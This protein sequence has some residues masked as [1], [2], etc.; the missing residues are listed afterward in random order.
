M[1]IPDAVLVCLF[2]ALTAGAEEMRY[3]WHAPDRAAK[4]AALIPGR[5]IAMPPPEEFLADWTRRQRDKWA[6]EHEELPLEEAYQTY[7]RAEP[8][9]EYLTTL[10]PDHISP[11]G[12]VVAG[13]PDPI[14]A[15]GVMI[16]Y[17]PFCGMQTAY[18]SLIRA[19]HTNPFHATTACCNQDLYEREQDFPP[20]YKL[21]P[22]SSAKFVHLDGTVH[23]PSAYTFTDKHGV[24]WRLFIG[25]VVTHTRWER[26]ASIAVGF[27]NQYRGTAN[28]LYAHKLAVLL[29]R[30][31]DVYY[32]LPLSYRNEL[33]KGRDGKPMTRAEW[34]ALPRPVRFGR[35]Y[36][37]LWNRRRPLMSRCWLFQ[38]KECIWVEPFARVRHHPTFKH[39]SKTKYGDP[40]A[41]DRKI[42]TKL[43][44][45]IALMFES[46]SLQSDY[47]DGAYTELMMLGI[48]LGNRYLFNFAAAHQE[49]VLYNHHYHDGMNGE[50]APNYMA[51]LTE[52]YRYLRDPKGWLELA[53]DFLEEHPF[54]GPAS[55]ELRKLYTVRGLPLEF[56][57][58]H[59]YAYA[60]GFATEPSQVRANEQRTSRNWP[61]YGIGILRVGGHGHRQEV[62]MTYDRVSL[63][64]AS[65]KLGIE[66]WVDG[67]PVMREGGYAAPSTYL[68]M[69]KSRPEVQ[70]LLSLPYPRPL[71]EVRQ[72]PGGEFRAR[73]YVS[74]HLSHN[75]VSVNEVGTG[76]GWSDNEGFGDLITFKGGEAPGVPGAHFQVLDCQDLYSFERMGV[77]VKE[78]R[79]TLLAV[80]GPDGRPYV[81]DVLRLHGG[82]RHAL[83]QSA[84]AELVEEHLP[85]VV[86][87]EPNLAVYLD[88]LRGQP[89]DALPK[90][91]LY[92]QI[93]HL[94]VLGD[95]P[96]TWDLTWEA[97]YAA[98]AP[99][100]PLGKKTRRPLAGDVGRARLRLM[101]LGEDAQTTLLRARGPWVAWIRQSLPGGKG[102]DGTVGFRDAWDYLIESRTSDDA[103]PLKSTYLHVLEG[104]RPG[105]Q[106]A[107]KRL[108]RLAAEQASG[109]V[110]GLRLEMA[111]GHTDTIVFQPKPGSVQFRD[112]LA[113]DAR[114]ALVRQD[115]EGAVSEAHLVRGTRL[116]CGS[117]SARAP[118]DFKG[119]IVDIIGDLTGTRLES[120]L[121]VRPDAPWP[122]GM[123]LAGRQMSIEVINDHREAYAIEKV[124][125]L[126]NGL[127]R[128]DMANH[129]PFAT[130]WHEVVLID[131]D[132]PNL[133][134]TNRQLWHGINTPWWW[135][136]KIWFPERG[137]TYTIRKTYSDRVTLEVAEQVDL[138]A[139]GVKPGDWFVIYAIEP[140]LKVT[141]PCE[142]AWQ[143]QLIAHAGSE[144]LRYCLRATGTAAITVPAVRGNVWRQTGSGGWQVAEVNREGNTMALTFPSDDTGGQTVRL[145]ARKPEW[146]KLEDRGPPQ[147]TSVSLDGNALAPQAAMELRRIPAPRRLIVKA[148][149]EDNPIDEKSIAVWLDG[150]RMTM[151]RG[152]VEARVDGRSATIECDL[153]R[154]LA[155]ETELNVP[156][157]H[158]VAIAM[159]DLAVD[160]ASASLS[161]SY[162]TRV[163]V[164]GDAI[165]LSDL[166]ETK[167]FVHG[168]LRKDTDYY[169]KPLRMRGVVYA[170]C[171]QTH[172]ER[173]T[174]P[175]SE[176]IYDLSRVPKRKKLC[177]LIGVDD[178]AGGGG[179]VT[180]HVQVDKDGA[181]ETR[182]ASPVLRGHQEPI[183]ITVDLSGAKK[184]RLYCT[185]AGDGINS[186]HATWCDAR[187]E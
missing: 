152:F 44:R 18:R 141:V 180:F 120:A 137:Q 118:G 60:G 73:D 33:A 145:V 5:K 178:G 40:E 70:A 4:V 29:D 31:A 51:M 49:C 130:G 38:G 132:R 168:G 7:A 95:A 116:Q 113:T 21:R 161:L 101:G 150:K 26:A 148:Q 173:A 115:A 164:S 121:I 138:A 69:D 52:Y 102:V 22:N 78:F 151:G 20:G 54:F 30:V 169:A 166:D 93:R 1:S 77:K 79:R 133:L 123:A 109:D 106:S 171:I 39:Y 63:H 61:G 45:E 181:W 55:A 175:H 184:L 179:S 131:P 128:V 88:T 24:T 89:P 124:T 167:A 108:T 99:R 43:L 81:V 127:L 58:Q 72:R 34:E 2:S 162:N 36:F 110:V 53:P 114:Y 15:A 76:R 56:A 147:I 129:A 144:H 57:D 13:K 135:G 158:T 186:D 42:T 19:G 172:V 94:K 122:V 97:D 83:F 104:Y 64:G 160:Q 6:D 16:T 59:M 67:V 96:E 182:Y 50:G 149:D 86:A 187:L 65:D 136:C 103:Q 85:S 165:Y 82:Q 134:K 35:P 112:G 183:A 140:G 23:E 32:G 10:I 143:R 159:D 146:L 174:P 126:P 117:F 71:F 46:Y 84:W 80:E 119:A 157:R 125:E 142:L 75:T 163:R 155:H 27:M 3:S 100:D 66:C 11:F 185:D 176:V 153:G 87:T 14:K 91:S 25:T 68:V 28:P 107:I 9:D 74:C 92:E 90:R 177:A 105:E 17:C 62:F 37:G 47:Q 139:E 12:Q 111:G 98:Y 154:A 170:K 48:L 156:A 8:S 41:L